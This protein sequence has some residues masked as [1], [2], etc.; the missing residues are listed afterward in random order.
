MFAKQLSTE[1]GGEFGGLV[2]LAVHF[3]V[4]ECVIF[5][6]DGDFRIVVSELGAI[7][8][9]C[10]ANYHRSVIGDEAFGVDIEFFA[11]E[12]VDFVRVTG[13]PGYRANGRAVQH[14]RVADAIVLGH[15]GPRDLGGALLVPIKL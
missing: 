11:D 5:D 10:G 1:G 14:I 2:G 8:E 13:G 12:G 9:V 3:R 7:I 15:S 6:D 4:D